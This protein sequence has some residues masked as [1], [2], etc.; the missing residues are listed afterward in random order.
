MSAAKLVVNRQPTSWA[1]VAAF[2]EPPL[3]C[4]QHRGRDQDRDE[5]DDPGVASSHGLSS[6]DHDDAGVDADPTAGGQ[7]VQCGGYDS[8]G[9]TA[10]R[11]HEGCCRHPAGVPDIFCIRSTPQT[12]TYFQ[13]STSRARR[14]QN[15]AGPPTLGCPGHSE[16]MRWRPA[17]VSWRRVPDCSLN[18]TVDSPSPTA[19]AG[20]T[21][22]RRHDCS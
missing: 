4:T 17:G 14:R 15:P 18:S 11:R 16:S 2:L 5:G 6:D 20:D 13:P 3:L 7:G 21:A 22:S 9:C 8:C 19:G 12:S 10:F 1:A